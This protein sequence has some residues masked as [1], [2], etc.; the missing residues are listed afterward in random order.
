[1]DVAFLF[2][3]SFLL[4][5]PYIP[6]TLETDGKMQLILGNVGG[7]NPGAEI[8]MDLFYKLTNS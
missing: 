4:L 5:K 8:S 7:R 3:L 1:M 2:P 6:R